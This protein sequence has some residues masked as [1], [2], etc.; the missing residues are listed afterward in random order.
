MTTP[1]F[2]ELGLIEPITRTLDEHNYITPT[3]IQLN[4][5]PIL[6][7]NQ[8]LLGIAQTGTGKTAAFSLPLL[9]HLFKT[10]C[11]PTPRKARAL[12][13]APTRELAI[14]IAENCQVYSKHL[15][16][17]QTTIFGGVNQK[18]QVKMMSKGVDLLIATPGRLLDLMQQGHIDLSSISHFVLDEADRMLDMGFINDIK[19][20]MAKIPKK[21]HTLLFSATMP[22]TISKLAKSLLNN[23][24]TVEVT[25]KVVTVEKI[26]QVLYKVG[27][28]EKRSLLVNLL[29]N[30][31]IT[32]AIIFSKTKHGANRIVQELEHSGISS[33][34][35]HGNKSQSARQKALAAFKDGEI[36][37]LVATDIAA[38]GIDVDKISHVINY[39]LPNE[40]E[41]YVHRIG[42]TARAGTKGSAISFCDESEHKELR[43]IE[44]VIR[45]K[46]EVVKTPELEKM[47]PLKLAPKPR[48]GGGQRRSNNAPNKNKNR[49][50]NQRNA[51]AGNKRPQRTSSRNIKKR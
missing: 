36:R 5:I 1:T 22:N 20:I 17:R 32:R 8:D 23:P 14:Q 46:I 6:L 15:S 2:H 40:P 26:D 37:T 43:A 27:K 47:E 4:A 49:N 50:S 41:S 3:P 51:S 35:I 30:K 44:R 25:P 18:P 21:R 24:K 48:Q 9:Q 33:A 38:R 29:Q 11:N 34:A 19:K 7:N 16:L 10:Q 12:V 31:D 42:R 45:F 39:D 13:L 28:K